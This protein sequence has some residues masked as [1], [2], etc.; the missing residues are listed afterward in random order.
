M[1]D[2]DATT[3]TKPPSRTTTVATRYRRE[4]DPLTMTWPIREMVGPKPALPRRAAVLL[5]F[6]E[7]PDMNGFGWELYV[8]PEHIATTDARGR[9]EFPWHEIHRVTIVPVQ[10]GRSRFHAIQ[11]RLTDAARRPRTIRPAGFARPTTFAFAVDRV[12]AH[13]CC[14]IGSTT[15][16][17]WAALTDAITG[18]AGERWRIPGTTST[19]SGKR[20]RASKRRTN[21]SPG[22]AGRGWMHGDPV[23]EVA[24]HPDR[25]REIPE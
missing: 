21:A 11:I 12:E 19:P 15:Y 6:T 10:Y 2:Y 18:Y 20:L 1:F 17:R 9:Q 14:V 22:R 24:R 3:V 16:E 4:D 8:G 23:V 7:E 13:P 5:G 25:G